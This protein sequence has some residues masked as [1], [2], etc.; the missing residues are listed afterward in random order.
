MKYFILD[1]DPMQL[2]KVPQVE[3]IQPPYNMNSPNSVFNA[4][5]NDNFQNLLVPTRLNLVHQAKWTDM[6]IAAPISF[7]YLIISERFKEMLVRLRLPEFFL[8]PVKITKREKELT[9][10][11]F[12]SPQ[13]FGEF[14][15]FGQCEAFIAKTDS[16]VPQREPTIIKTY[17]EYKRRQSEIQ[18]NEMIIIANYSIQKDEIPYDIFRL[19]REFK[20]AHRYLVSSLFVDAALQAGITGIIFEPIE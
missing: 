18:A 8:Y 10:Y 6:I 2:G 20:D 5:R 17:E 7:P 12:V 19:P 9:Y 13:R 1:F 15:D 16:L 3:S 4:F 14:A 11:I